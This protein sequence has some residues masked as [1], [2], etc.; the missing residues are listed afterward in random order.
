MKLIR[1]YMKQTNSSLTFMKQF[2][3]S[4]LDVG[5]IW[6]S[7]RKLCANMMAG[8]DLQQVTHV[9]ELGAGTGVLTRHLLQALPA[10]SMLDVYEIDPTFITM[11]Q[12]IQD[13]RLAIFM[14]P[15]EYLDKAYDVIFSGLPLLAFTPA[16]RQALLVRIKS[17]LRP[18]GHF[19]QFQYTAQLE[20]ELS[21]HF[22]WQRRRVWLNVPPA[23]VYQC[24]FRSR[25]LPT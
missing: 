15:A 23:W 14:Q 18:G 25:Q 9:A 21:H 13:P 7:S 17:A 2:V 20:R 22:E 16:Q 10:H 12:T 24:N 3:R 6:P 8:V 4:P 1:H 19:V 5:A 11:L